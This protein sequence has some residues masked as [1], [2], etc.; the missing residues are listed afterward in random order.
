MGSHTQE[1]GANHGVLSQEVYGVSVHA[2]RSTRHTNIGEPQCL[3]AGICVCVSAVACVGCV[4]VSVYIFV[5]FYE[6]T[7]I[8]EVLKLGAVIVLI[9]D[10]D[11]ELADSNKG[12]CSLV[13]GRH[14]HGIFSL[15]LPVELPRRDDHT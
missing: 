6:L 10:E 11:V 3:L 13:G 5:F 8:S 14:R 2:T 15:L 1:T 9:K 4:C 7:F 12:V